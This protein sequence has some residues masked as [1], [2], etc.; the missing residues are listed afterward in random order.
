[1]LQI[2]EYTLGLMFR[3]H[4]HAPNQRI[5]TRSGHSKLKKN[6][7]RASDLC[8][9]VIEEVELGVVSALDVLSREGIDGQASDP[10]VDQHPPQN[11]V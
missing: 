4:A 10:K 1:M 8:E 9:Q 7:S 11:L 2:R 5:H 3:D 6:R